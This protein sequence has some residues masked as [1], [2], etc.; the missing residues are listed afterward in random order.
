MEPRAS[1]PRP[2]DG[3]TAPAAPALADDPYAL[4]QHGWGLLAR[5]DKKG[6][7]DGAAD[8]FRRALEHDPASADAHAGLARACWRKYHNDGKD[9]QWLEQAL[10]AA[11][12]AALLDDDL[13]A[14]QISLGH[15]LA[16]S[17]RFDEA[18]PCFERARR[19]DPASAAPWLGL[20]LLRD[21]TGD[22]AGAAKAYREGLRLDPDNPELLDSLCQ[23]D[24]RAGR[25]VEAEAAC[26]ASVAAAP[27]RVYGYR[28]LA[29]VLHSRGDVAG[30][31]EQLQAALAIQ[32]ESTVYANL[33]TLHY[34]QGL[35]AEAAAAFEKS[36]EHGGG[37]HLYL[38]WANLAD[39][40][41]QL[42]GRDADAR[43]AYDVAIRLARQELSGTA[44]AD[45]ALAS[46]IA[47]YQAR[48]GPT[49]ES[50]SQLENAQAAQ[51]AAKGD[52]WIAHRLAL[53]FELSGRRDRALRFLGLAL[54]GGHPLREIETEPDLLE[55]RSDPEYQRLLVNLEPVNQAR[56]RTA[57][58]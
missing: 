12:R 47:L 49:A 6:H 53:A 51:N 21:W 9:P 17:K 16:S 18:R 32:P 13:A 46:R 48:R 58:R 43:E 50:R 45:V 22:P 55:L 44:D 41:R 56:R 28:N 4:R 7:V 3:R 57:G 14:A 38:L 24:Y 37:A 30:A 26:R 5:F 19:L 23:L 8:A 40:Y 54:R 20:G 11:E 29:A 42:P 15:A 2:G 33:G 35:Y 34:F 39:A 10:R 31:A 27:D 52:P 25:Y 36:L 1:G